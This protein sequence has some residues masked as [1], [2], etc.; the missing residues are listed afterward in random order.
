MGRGGPQRR[1]E[2]HLLKTGV[3]ISVMPMACSK[4]KGK[5]NQVQIHRRQTDFRSVG[6]GRSIDPQRECVQSDARYFSSG[7][8]RVGN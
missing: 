8:L 7:I 6:S 3:K 2:E 5:A 1:G 4:Q